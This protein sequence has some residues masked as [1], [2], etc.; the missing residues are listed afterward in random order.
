[1]RTNFDNKPIRR[2]LSWLTNT[3][4]TDADLAEALEMPTTTFS[5]RKDDDEFPSFEELSTLAEHF[6]LSERALQITFGY[7]GL[8]AMILLDE[9]S[10]WEF[11]EQGGGNHPHP[12]MPVVKPVFSQLPGHEQWSVSYGDDEASAQ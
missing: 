8:D 1:M 4:L 3:D 11:N 10:M 12:N 9:K 6:K 7:L 5:R 2:V